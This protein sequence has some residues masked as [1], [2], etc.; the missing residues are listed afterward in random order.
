MYIG[1]LV[2][3]P[4]CG[5]APED[6]WIL[7][8]DV[9]AVPHPSPLTAFHLIVAPRRHVAA[10]YDLDVGEQRHVWDVVGVLR[11]R[12]AATIPVEG[13]DVGFRDGD[14]GDPAAHVEVHLVPRPK[15]ARPQ[16]PDGIEWVD[17]DS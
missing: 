5:A 15:G 13:F 7:T 11:E 8:E 17:L 9:V 4:Y 1:C 2:T 6:A 3:C 12:I 16:L 10:F 14:Q